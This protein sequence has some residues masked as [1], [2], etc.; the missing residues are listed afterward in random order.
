MSNKTF[1]FQLN[2]TRDCNL[3]CTHCYISTDKK[4]ESQ[5]MNDAQ[6]LETFDQ[7]IDYMKSDYEGRNEYSHA[8]IHIIGGEPTMLGNA[9]FEKNMPLVREKLKEMKQK[10][11]LSL[12]TNLI[13]NDSIK[14]A[15]MFDIISTSYEYET[16]FL[17]KTGK[18]KPALETKWLN[19]V[20]ILREAGVQANVT[21][22]VTKQAVD[23]GAKTILDDFYGRG[24][25][26]VHLGFFIP[27]GDGLLN[28]GTVFPM[29]HETTQFMIDATT[30]Y[31]ERRLKDRNLYI[32]PVESMIESIHDQKPMDDIV[33]PIIPGA[34]DIDWNGDTVTCIEAGGEVDMNSLGNIY[35]KPIK[36]ILSS[37]EY[38]RE[39]SKAIIA[40]PACRGCDELLSCQSAC[41]V[42]HQYWN[43]RGECPGFKGFIKHIRNLVENENLRP[44]RL[45]LEIEARESGRMGC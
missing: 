45:E 43:G 12:V 11:S 40:K 5:Y 4:A 31:L 39:K 32:N 44:K 18:P 19:N 9:F 6:F 16:R 7:I 33:C 13:T 28:M 15:K 37:R 2:V 27:S 10:A 1:L 36:E 25:K 23:R 26:E 34:L 22:A 20:E 3:R 8:E 29:F 14:I 38:R 24:F 21:M 17:S 30:W 41:G 35:E 42:L